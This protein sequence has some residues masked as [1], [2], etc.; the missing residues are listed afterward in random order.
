[1]AGYFFSAWGNF[2]TILGANLIQPPS[3]GL[4]I[5]PWTML[6]SWP[7]MICALYLQYA[8]FRKYLLVYIGRA[9]VNSKKI[10]TF[11]AVIILLFEITYNVI[12]FNT[13]GITIFP[14][15]AINP[16]I[17]FCRLVISIS[18]IAIAIRFGRTQRIPSV[19]QRA[20]TR[21]TRSTGR[22]MTRSPQ[23]SQR[24]A[25]RPRPAPVPRPT[26]PRAQPSQPRGMFHRVVVHTTK[27]SEDMANLDLL[28][29]KASVLSAE[30]FKCIFC[31]KLPKLPEDEKRGIVI[32]PSCRHPAH[33]DEFISWTKNS[34]LCSRCDT[35]IPKDFRKKPKIIPTSTYVE[36][37]KRY[38]K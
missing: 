27:A 29:P 13:L 2:T 16:Y 19:A 33:A 37:I 38:S 25:P 11:T 30:D 17:D 10:G 34:P 6:L 23:T 5:S 22:V 31:F 35:Q 21:A 15:E 1:M 18:T 32:C 20:A 24:P 3:S 8:C 28:R 4:Y 36:V 12:L 26:Q 14:V 9:S 7:Y